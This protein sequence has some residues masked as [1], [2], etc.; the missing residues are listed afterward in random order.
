MMMETYIAESNFNWEFKKLG[1][2][3]TKEQIAIDAS[4]Y[5]Y[6]AAE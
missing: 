2:K 6:D 3:A 4:K 1:D 5:L